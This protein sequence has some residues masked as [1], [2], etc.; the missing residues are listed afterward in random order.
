MLKHFASATKI[1]FI[2]MAISLVAMVFKGIVTGEQ[3]LPLVTMVFLSYYKGKS[4]SE[5]KG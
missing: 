1:V 2:I 3:F 5:P 4:N